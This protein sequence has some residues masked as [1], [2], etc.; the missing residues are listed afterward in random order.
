MIYQWEIGAVLFYIYTRYNQKSLLLG[1]Y[2]R[3]LILLSSLKI[4]FIDLIMSGDNAIVIAFATRW[5]PKTLRKKAMYAWVAGA[6]IMRILLA[7]VAVYLLQYPVLKYVW[8]VMLMYV[9]WTFFR[10][11]KLW[12]K[13]KKIASKSSLWWAIGVIILADVSLSL[14][15]VL[16]VAAIAENIRILAWGLIVSVAMMMFA[17][18]AIAKLMERHQRIQRWGLIVI[19]HTGLGIL[20]ESELWLDILWIPIGIRGLMVMCAVITYLYIDNVV[21]VAFR[22]RKHHLHNHIRLWIIFSVFTIF[23]LSDFVPTIHDALHTYL[24]EWLSLLFIAY[25]MFLELVMQQWSI[26]KYYMKHQSRH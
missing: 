16:A 3:M 24:T 18:Q 22:L 15:N 10:T 5:L 20:I 8:W 23:F 21:R 11:L 13:S 4:I 14:D 1:P 2:Y 26:D 9:A 17:S 19:I 6:A 12:E 7:S 25:I